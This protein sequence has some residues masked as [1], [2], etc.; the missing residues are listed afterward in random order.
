MRYVACD[1]GLGIKAQAG[2]KHLHLLAG[3][4][5]RLIENYERIIQRAAA[6]KSEGGNFDNTLLQK[7]FEFVSVEHVVQGVIQRAHVGV[8]FL[9]QC[10]GQKSEALA[11]FHRR[12]REDDAV[13]LLSQ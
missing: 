10:A 4:I 6:H 12:A 1:D 7:S 5:L 3:G 8:D 11:G 9:L 2:Q 13:D